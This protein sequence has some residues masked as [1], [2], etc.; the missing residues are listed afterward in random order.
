MKLFAQL[1]QDWRVMED[2]RDG[3]FWQYVL[4][5]RMRA[6]SKR[7]QTWK[8]ICY[9]DK[10][11]LLRYVQRHCMERVPTKRL[12]GTAVEFKDDGRVICPPLWEVGH[13]YRNPG[14]DLSRIVSV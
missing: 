7:S 12:I 9:P 8:D 14:L 5:K 1:S 3:K 6:T 13:E 11:G 2:Q 10:R 4:Q